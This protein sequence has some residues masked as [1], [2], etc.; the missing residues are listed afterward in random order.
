MW[1]TLSLNRYQ[2]G[3]QGCT[4]LDRLKSGLPAEYAVNPLGKCTA[5]AP[6]LHRAHQA[7]KTA[8]DA[9]NPCLAPDRVWLIHHQPPKVALLEQSPRQPSCGLDLKTFENYLCLQ[10][11]HPPVVVSNHVQLIHH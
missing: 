8:K 4:Y 9:R 5:R 1:S 7:H 11:P 3:S 2:G 6:K 10:S